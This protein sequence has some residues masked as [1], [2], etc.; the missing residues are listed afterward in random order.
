MEYTCNL[1]VKNTNSPTFKTSNCNN[2]N[3]ISHYNFNG[4]LNLCQLIYPFVKQGLR[5]TN[6]ITSFDLITKNIISVCCVSW[7]RSGGCYL[8]SKVFEDII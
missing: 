7:E 8:N 2:K 5:Y 6:K 3:Y 4:N 1:Y